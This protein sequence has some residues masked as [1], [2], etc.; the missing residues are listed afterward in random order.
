MF[1]SSSR[2]LSKSRT[3]ASPSLILSNVVAFFSVLLSICL[4]HSRALFRIVVLSTIVSNLLPVLRINLATEYHTTGDLRYC[5]DTSDNEISSPESFFQR[6]TLLPDLDLLLESRLRDGRYRPGTL[7]RRCYPVL[8]ASSL[9]P[10]LHPSSELEAGPSLLHAAIS[11][12]RNQFIQCA[13][14][15]RNVLMNRTEEG[16]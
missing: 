7:N 6:N 13:Q 12:T 5:L 3:F 11:Q 1:S 15:T 4:P 9:L 10:P 14:R 2:R 16:L 8:H